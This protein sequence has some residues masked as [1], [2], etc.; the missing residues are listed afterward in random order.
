M[1]DSKRMN[2][3]FDLPTQCVYIYVPPHLPHKLMH[4]KSRRCEYIHRADAPH[5]V[6]LSWSIQIKFCENLMSQD[7]RCETSSYVCS[8]DPP[9]MGW[10]KTGQKYKKVSVMPNK[11]TPV[12]SAFMPTVIPYSYNRLKTR[13]LALTPGQPLANSQPP[14]DTTHPYFPRKHFAPSPNKYPLKPFF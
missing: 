5:N 14:Y 2:H 3:V 11:N 10:P 4:S 12:T 9:S 6:S 1:P 7:E 13:T 8:P